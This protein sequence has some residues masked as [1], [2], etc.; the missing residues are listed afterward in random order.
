MIKLLRQTGLRLPCIINPPSIISKGKYFSA[1]AAQQICIDYAKPTPFLSPGNL[2]SYLYGSSIQECMINHDLIK[3]QAF[4]CQIL[5]KG[6]CL[7]LFARNVLLNFYVKSDLLPHACKLFDEMP[8]RNTI[9]MVTLIQGLG[10]AGRFTDALSFFSMIHREG[11]ELNPFVFTTVLKLFVSMEYPQLGW[12]IHAC[13]YKLGQDCD[14]FVGTALIDS[15]SMCGF[16]GIARDVF[17]G[18]LFKDMISWSGMVAG[19]AEN[20]CFEEGLQLYVEMLRVG[21]MPNNFTLASGLKASVGLGGVCAAKSIHGCAFKTGYEKDNYVG[22]ALLDLYTKF[23]DLCEAEVVFKDMPK[24]DVIPWSFMIARCAQ[25]DR[26]D[27]AVDIF[28]QMRKACVMPNQFTLASMLQACASMASLHMGK[29]MHCIVMK[30]GLDSNVFV[31]NALM[32]VYAK[33]ERIEDSLALFEAS[34]NKNDVTWNTMI[35]GYGQ[36]GDGEKALIMFRCMLEH[37]VL[38]TEVTYSSTLRT[39]A[40]LAAADSGR[41]I[42]AFTVKTKFDKDSVVGNSLIDMYAK[43][44]NIKPARL[45]FDSM[46]KRDEVSWNAII[47]AYAMHGLGKEA[48]RMFERMQRTDCKPNKLT[49]V[50]VLSACSNMGLLDEGQA[51]FASMIRD[52]GIEP[53]VE[54]YTCMVWLLGRSGNLDKAMKLIMEMPFEPSIMIWRA[55]LGACVIHKNVELGKVA[56]EHVLEMEPQDESAYVLLSNIYA[57]VKRWGHVTH[58]RKS[59]KKK[60]VKKE[61]GL[62]WVEIQGDLHY[63][64]VGDTSHPDIRLIKGMLEW[65]KMRIYREG[66]IAN[67]NVVLLD[68]EDEEK[69]RFVWSHSERLALAFAL[70]RT[71][72]G[73]PVRILKNLRICADCHAAVKLISKVVQREIVVRDINRFHHFQDGSCSCGDYW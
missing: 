46:E 32:D 40:S 64:S 43:C 51:Y 35:V 37:N 19:Y 69:E 47:S 5:K 58:V 12:N 66:Y 52:Y 56:A 31:S 34:A 25:T 50:G 49:F 9:S 63:F 14:A 20:A 17:D 8:E 2:N 45:I 15:Y 3:G 67:C 60:G 29:Q 22:I 10:K 72:L 39:C 23:G 41:Q 33:C 27:L 65:L 26:S 30:V 44:G 54:H 36:L 48:L 11:H 6:N 55:V 18:I 24:K 62:S 73:S 42:H 1:Q 13:I 38:P 53:C 70:V 71:P 7:D 68:V 4:H 28:H 16:V 61:P 21:F 57:S 59:M